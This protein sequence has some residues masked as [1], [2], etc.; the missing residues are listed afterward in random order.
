MNGE[1]AWGHLDE[2]TGRILDISKDFLHMYFGYNKESAKTLMKTFIEEYGDTF[3]EDEI[4]R[5]SAYRIAAISH[6][7]VGLQG[8]R[9]KLGHWL[10]ESG[11]QNSPASALQYFRENYFQ[12]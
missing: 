12:R 11:H 2:D 8:Q 1:S 5:Q 4:H 7:L 10:I 9:E 3:D 6:Y